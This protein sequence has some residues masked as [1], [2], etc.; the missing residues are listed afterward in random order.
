MIEER[1]G[2]KRKRSDAKSQRLKESLK[3]QH[4]SE[5]VIEKGQTELPG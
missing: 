5:K 3:D 4:Q 2:I 1:R